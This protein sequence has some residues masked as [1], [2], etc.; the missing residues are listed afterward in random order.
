MW[1]TF[2]NVGESVFSTSQDVSQLPTLVFVVGIEGAG[3]HMMQSILRDAVT[4]ATGSEHDR[5]RNTQSALSKSLAYFPYIEAK[6][7]AGMVGKPAHL[8]AT[9][10]GTNFSV[11]KKAY[12]DHIR[13]L[14]KQM[15]SEEDKKSF[16]MLDAES[17]YPLM[18]PRNTLRRPD[19]TWLFR[20]DGDIL[21]LRL[22]FMYREPSH[23][24]ISSVRRF[25]AENVLQTRI[26]EDNMVAIV[27]G[28]RNLP[29]SVL[30]RDTTS[31]IHMK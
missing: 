8:T 5:S 21:N 4:G 9:A 13:Y 7:W 22:L 3:H 6:P 10:Y 26:L 1:P 23:A 11:F 17:S 12:V 25:A 27:G 15:S 2:A 24:L 18:D 29:A 28:L 20:L 14:R 31:S 30:A 19:L 16:F